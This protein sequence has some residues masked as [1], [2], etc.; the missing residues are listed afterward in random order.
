MS[1]L[2]NIKTKLQDLKSITSSKK[3][4]LTN[5]AESLSE[6]RS[7]DID[8]PTQPFYTE[9]SMVVPSINPNY[10][11]RPSEIAKNGWILNTNGDKNYK[12][13]LK[14]I[15]LG[16]LKAKNVC[17]TGTSQMY[18]RVKGQHIIDYQKRL[19]D[20]Y[21]VPPEDSDGPEQDQS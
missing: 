7:A 5:Q 11:Y 6:N 2:Q 4:G 16:K 15:R 17:V 9:P 10:M 20:E 8:N 19:T 14:L 13:I 18:F 21:Y 3:S 1:L 12:F